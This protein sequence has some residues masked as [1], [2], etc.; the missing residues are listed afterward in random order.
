M[1][2]ALAGHEFI[3]QST[4]DAEPASAQLGDFRI[5]R[6]VGRGGMGVVYGVEQI[7]RKRRVALKVLR[8]GAR[9]PSARTGHA[10]DAPAS[11]CGT[12]SGRPRRSP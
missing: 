3:H 7:S 10:L 4:R 12:D 9:A 2:Q 8:Y 6:Q 5:R 11:R 1:E